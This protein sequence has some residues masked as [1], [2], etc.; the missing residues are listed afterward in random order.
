MEYVNRTSFNYAHVA[1]RLNYPGHT[2]TLIVKG[3]FDLHHKGT[4]SPSEEQLYPTGDEFYPDDDEMTGSS[5]YEYDFAFYKPRTDL[6]CAGHCYS[7][8][9]KPVP[10]SRV[11]FRV[12]SHSRTLYVYGNRKWK[13]PPGMRVISDPEPFTSMEL[14]YD[15]SFGGLEYKKNPVGKGHRKEKNE[16]G[17]NEWLL[18]NI[19][20]PEHLIDSPDSSPE[21]AGYGP[22]GRMWKQR[23]SKMGTYTGDWKTKRWPWFP[24]DFDWSHFNAAT[25]AMQ[26]E[27]YLRGDEP[28]FFENM[29]SEHARYESR[30][31][32]TRVRCFLNTLPDANT[33][34]TKFSEV[35]IK[36]DTLWADMDAEK[37]VLV[38]R[39]SAE[40]QSEEY[41]EV[42]HVFIMSEPVDQEPASLEQCYKLFLATQAA[43]EEEFA[44]EPEKPEEAEIPEK[45]AIGAPKV[46]AQGIAAAEAAAPGIAAAEVTEF[47]K[48]KPEEELPTEEIS[49]IDPATV[50]AQAI[51]L[52]A[53]SGFD[54]E[55]LPPDSRNRIDQEMDKINI[56]GGAIALGHPLGCTGAK[57][58]ATLLTNMK[59]RGVKYGI[60]A[61]CIGGGMGAAALFEMC[62]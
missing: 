35:T 23:F 11:T 9:G 1:G 32:G 55:K 51:A 28:L 48:E 13:G 58:C 26:V 52:L 18:P 10:A 5:R 45:P 12:G 25:P 20:D 62:A 19:E 6:L 29:H 47:E 60:E 44:I 7:Q 15:N 54:M 3:T 38:W 17:A 49:P 33:N 46:T 43:E 37:L 14:R 50:K 36:L 24:L 40:I 41:E 22:L 4:A 39:G 2:L 31:P 59:E 30:L 42:Q 27:G 34:E 53:Q 8:G 61:M 16:A 57:L 56:H 21:P